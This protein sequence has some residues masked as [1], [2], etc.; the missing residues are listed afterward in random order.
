MYNVL[1]SDVARFEQ[2]LLFF[3]SNWEC[4]QI[5]QLNRGGKLFSIIL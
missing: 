5:R 1:N 2:K 3:F 4:V